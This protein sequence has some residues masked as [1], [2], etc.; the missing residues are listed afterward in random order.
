MELPTGSLPVPAWLTKA[1]VIHWPA[2]APRIALT[3]A[4]LMVDVSRMDF[5]PALAETGRISA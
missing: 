3:T 5:A 2:E 1:K 4:V